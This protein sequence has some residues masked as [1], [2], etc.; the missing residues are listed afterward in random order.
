MKPITAVDLLG[1]FKTPECLFILFF[2]SL[3][4]ETENKKAES[5]RLVAPSTKEETDF[6]LKPT[7][8]TSQ[9]VCGELI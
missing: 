9:C 3:K 4:A 7:S 1:R 8:L 2:G 5:V 6:S